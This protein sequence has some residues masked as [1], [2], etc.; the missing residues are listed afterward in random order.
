MSIP[1]SFL[2]KNQDQSGRINGLPV[3]NCL[4]LSLIFGNFC[5][6]FGNFWQFLAIF[7]LSN[8]VPI[9]SLFVILSPVIVA[10][11]FLSLLARESR[12]WHL[13]YQPPRPKSLFSCCSTS[14]FLEV[15]L[16]TLFLNQFL[17]YASA[18]APA[19]VVLI[20][21]FL[22]CFVYLKNCAFNWFI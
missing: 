3:R 12:P 19:K 20:L 22:A 15:S 2:P 21:S 7:G 9:C 14:L 16:Q 8:F 18:S 10:S 6:I 11:L 1:E 17:P 4:V 5:L 13:D